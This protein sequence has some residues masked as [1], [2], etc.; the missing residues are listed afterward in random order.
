MENQAEKPVLP[1]VSEETQEAVKAAI[2]ETLDLF[3][4][5]SRKMAESLADFNRRRAEIQERLK[6]GARRTSGRI[7]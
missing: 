1:Q 5:H 4:D 2:Q 7:V 3:A 6:N